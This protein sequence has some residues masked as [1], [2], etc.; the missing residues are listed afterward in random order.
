M[1]TD[2]VSFVSQD[3]RLG[4]RLVMPDSGAANLG[5]LCVTGGGLEDCDT[6]YLEIQQ[7]MAEEAGLASLAFNARGIG[8][9]EGSFRT[10]SANFDHVSAPANSQA[11]R[12]ADTI[13]AYKFLQT[14]LQTTEDKSMGI[15][16]GS[17]GG[18]ITVRALHELTPGAVVLRAPSAYPD[19][20]HQLKYGPEWGPSIRAAGEAAALQSSNFERLSRLTLPMLLVYSAGD[21]VIPKPIHDSYRSAVEAT[22]GDYLLVGDE[23]TP[24]T[25]LK[26]IPQHDTPTIMQ[27][28]EQVYHATAKFFKN[29]LSAT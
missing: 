12:T 8:D 20:I 6:S 21:E 9:S 22:G 2:R 14:Q 16:G 10:D 1:I 3:V 25:F 27:A 4:G 24:H 19:H 26:A 23:A 15:I 7:F 5:V 18:D 13:T 17:M 28:R 29:N 11:S